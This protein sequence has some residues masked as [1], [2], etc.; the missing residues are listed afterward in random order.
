MLQATSARPWAAIFRFK[1]R[2]EL[3]HLGNV[4][5]ALGLHAFLFLYK[6]NIQVSELLTGFPCKVLSTAVTA[7]LGF[8]ACTSVRAQIPLP[9]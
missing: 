4:S 5:K 3:S 8:H 7:A 6:A 1:A 2:T 9:C